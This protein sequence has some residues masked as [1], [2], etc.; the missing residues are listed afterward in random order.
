MKTQ[1]RSTKTNLVQGLV[2]LDYK[3]M[4]GEVFACF[5]Y[6]DRACAAKRVRELAYGKERAIA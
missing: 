5:K 3:K 6:R 1:E 4:F 2:T